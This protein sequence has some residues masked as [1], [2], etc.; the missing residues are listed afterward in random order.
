MN[1]SNKTLY[2]HKLY[3][4]LKELNTLSVNS[5]ADYES[6]Y[7]ELLKKYGFTEKDWY[8]ACRLVRSTPERLCFHSNTTWKKDQQILKDKVAHK[9]EQNLL[10]G[11]QEYFDKLGETEL[12]LQ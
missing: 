3:S 4:F 9:V 6:I 10:S 8:K 7:A 12:Q 1:N 11:K 5:V 2:E